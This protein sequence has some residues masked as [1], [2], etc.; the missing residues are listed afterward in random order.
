MNLLL[1]IN[2]GIGKNILATAVVKNYRKKYP[3]S[4]I[5]ILTAWSDVW[6][7]NNEV[8]KVLDINRP[9]SLYDDY[10]SMDYKCVFYDPYQDEDY[11]RGTKHLIEIWCNLC[12]C[13]YDSEI[14]P[15]IKFNKSEEIRNTL[16]FHELLTNKLLILQANGGSHN[17]GYS[18]SRD[19]PSNEV[20]DIIKPYVDEYKILQIRT[21]EQ[22][23]FIQEEYN[24]SL[25][26]WF[27]LI[28]KASKLILIDSFAQHCARAVD[29]KADVY[30]IGG[31]H[32]VVGYELHNNIYPKESYKLDYDNNYRL[33]NNYDIMG[34]LYECP[35]S[36][37]D[38][39]FQKRES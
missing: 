24:F 30:W 27:W 8:D 9:N 17:Q 1:S 39:I 10:I 29:K 18:W 23:K 36:D 33:S 26:E 3:N 38:V 19:L 25:R 32:E 5:V 16:K 28:S 2:G 4:E 37:D 14:Q 6:L 12:E 22:P 35:F 15:E 31:K 7:N 34:N 21:P 13:E 20:L 11:L